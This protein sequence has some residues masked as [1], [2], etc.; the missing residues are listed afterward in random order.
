M[1]TVTAKCDDCGIIIKNEEIFKNYDNI[2]LCKKCK[3]K[4][5]LC[6]A[7]REYNELKKWLEV[8]HL[9]QL[10]QLKDRMKELKQQIESEK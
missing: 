8:T 7:K 3:L 2:F 9:L 5:D 4:N 6:C 10:K 1:G